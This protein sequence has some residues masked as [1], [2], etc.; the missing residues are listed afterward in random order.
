MAACASSL[1]AMT[2]TSSA[3]GGDEVATA[4]GLRLVEGLG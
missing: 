2:T 1:A 3:P 4:P